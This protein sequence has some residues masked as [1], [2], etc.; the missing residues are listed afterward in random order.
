MKEA[1]ERL[2]L[3]YNEL[4]ALSWGSILLK[5]EH[6]ERTYRQM[7]DAIHD[8]SGWLN[9]GRGSDEERAKLREDQIMV[10]AYFLNLGKK[11][12]FK[13]DHKWNKG[14]RDYE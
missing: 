12:G 11:M 8:G 3:R 5:T 14:M 13:W 9:G 7:V 6:C 4:K 10:E 2:L 1:H